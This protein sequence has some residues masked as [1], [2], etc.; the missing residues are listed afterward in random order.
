MPLTQQ[1]EQW[2]EEKEQQR[3]IKSDEFAKQLAAAYAAKLE[4]KKEKKDKGKDSNKKDKDKNKKDSKASSAQAL[5]A[6]AAL[7]K[8]EENKKPKYSSANQFMSIHFP[9]FEDDDNQKTQAPMRTMQLIE[10]SRIINTCQNNDVDIKE[11]CLRKA[12]IIPQD[13]PEAICLEGLQEDK[14]RLMIN[15]N[16]REFWRKFLSK[17]KK[18]KRGKK[19]KK[20]K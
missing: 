14:K 19:G 9:N 7:L 2:L 3:Q 8:E 20:K 6:A 17:G 11:S 13:K 1:Q 5:A 18:G 12:L 10:V 15:P 4:K 16:P